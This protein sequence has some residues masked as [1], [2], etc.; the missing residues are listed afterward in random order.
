MCSLAC[1][2]RATSQCTAAAGATLQMTSARVKGGAYHSSTAASGP[3]HQIESSASHRG[4]LRIPEGQDREQ[5]RSL[6][7]HD[8]SHAPAQGTCRAFGLPSP[9]RAAQNSAAS[10]NADILE[11]SDPAHRPLQAEVVGGPRT[12]TPHTKQRQAFPRQEVCR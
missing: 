9:M 6:R 4:T 2:L 1:F 5:R 10:W 11:F 8:L 3:L 7:F 12:P